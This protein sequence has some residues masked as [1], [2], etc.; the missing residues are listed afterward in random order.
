MTGMLA[1]EVVEPGERA[2]ELLEAIARK[3]DFERIE[4]AQQPW[5][6]IDL[7]V[8]DLQAAIEAAEDALD[9][10]GDDGRYIVRVKR[11]RVLTARSRTCLSLLR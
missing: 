11:P 6:L 3:L 10:M 1:L 2:D 9:E 8:N 7:H 5:E 4:S